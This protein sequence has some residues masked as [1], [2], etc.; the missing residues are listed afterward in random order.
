MRSWIAAMALGALA[1][2]SWF[3]GDDDH[4]REVGVEEDFYRTTDPVTGER[5]ESDTAHRYDHMGRTYY[6]SSEENMRRFRENPSAYVDNEGRIP[7]S[8][9]AD[10]ERDRARDVR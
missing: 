10:W 5:V 7:A 2:C 1:G 6:F 4:D 8:R 3:D 9:R